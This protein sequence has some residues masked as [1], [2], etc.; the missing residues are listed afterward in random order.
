MELSDFLLWL[1]G[2]GA[3][4]AAYFIIKNLDIQFTFY[5][6]MHRITFRRETARSMRR[7]GIV[8]PGA[9]AAAGY[10]LAVVLGYTVAPVDAKAWLEAL[11]LVS[12]AAVTAQLMHGE[13]ELASF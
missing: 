5:G 2:P 9:I 6:L 12:T 10:T 3:G 4:I 11:F 8:L 13:K 7:W 1:I